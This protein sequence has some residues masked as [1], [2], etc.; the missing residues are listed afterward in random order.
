M[1]KCK[2]SPTGKHEWVKTKEDRTRR[3]DWGC[4]PGFY[5]THCG[6]RRKTIKV[7]KQPFDH[8]GVPGENTV[9]VWEDAWE[10][11]GRKWHNE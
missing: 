9:E 5:C 7:H 6:Q 10:A 2:K 3:T 8:G 4:I 11:M 1:V